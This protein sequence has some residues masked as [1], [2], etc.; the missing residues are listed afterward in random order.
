MN[1]YRM[2]GNT[3]G[4]PEALEL[5]ERLA[6][7]HDAMVAHERSAPSRSACD[8]DCPHEEARV[9]WEEAQLTFGERA[10]ELVFLRSRGMRLHRGVPRRATRSAEARL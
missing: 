7:W 3:V 8:E 2:M 9:F 1:L 5:A 10:S 4:T 6:S